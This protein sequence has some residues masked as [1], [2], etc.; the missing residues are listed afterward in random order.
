MSEQ[1][2]RLKQRRKGHRGVVT[3]LIKEAASLLEGERVEKSITRLRIIDEQLTEKLKVLRGFDEDMVT[4]IDVKEIENDVLEAEA[5]A[6][7]VSQLCGEIKAYLKKPDTLP[8]GMSTDASVTETSEITRRNTPRLDESRVRP[9]LPKLY[10][11]KFSGEVIHFQSFWESFTSAVHQN[12]DLSV[13]DKFNYLKGLVEGPAASAIQGLTL[14][15]GNYAAALELLKERFGKKQNIIAAHME[16]L[17]KLPN[18]NGDK[19]VQIRLVYDKIN[20]NV[21]ALEALGIAREQYGCLLI[22]VIMTKLPYN[23]RLQI[24]RLTKRDV[25]VVDELL[26]V[27]KNEVEAREM[28]E[29]MKF[30]DTRN[31]D[32]QKRLPPPT[33]ASLLV[34]EDKSKRKVQCI[35]CKAEHYSASCEKINTISGRVAVL[36]REGRCFLCLSNGHRVSECSVNRRCRK[37]GRKHHQS[38]CEQNIAPEPPKEASG[39][40][41]GSD[42]S[43]PKVT[44]VARCKNE[45]LLQTARTFAYTAN[46]DLVPVRILMDA[47]SQRSYLSNELKMRLKLKPLKQETL[48]VNTFGSE[49]FNKK[50]CDLVKVRLQAKQGKDV[51]ITALSYHAICSPLQIPV[52]PQQYS[53]LQELDLADTS[54]SK[55][56]SDKV[57]MLI[58][59]DFYWDIVTGDIKRGNEGPTAVSSKFGWLLSGPVNAGNKEVN[60]ALSNLVIEGVGSLSEQC[61]DQD[62]S[63]DLHRFWETESIG[64]AEETQTASM[65]SLFVDL[66]YDWILGRYQVTLPWKTDFRPQG[67]GYEISMAR[68]N[69]LRSKLQR[70]KSLFQQYDATFKMQV[71]DGIIEHIPSKTYQDGCYFLPHHAVIKTDRETTKLR[72]VF[73]AS[74]KANKT[75]LSLN[76]CLEKGPNGIPHIF[77]LL[78]NFRSHP[79]G[80]TADIEKAFH[81]IVIDPKDR[82]ALRFLWIDDIL[83]PRPEVIQ[84][85]FCRLVFGLTPSPAILTETIQYHLTRFLLKEP[86]MAELLSQ[87]FYVDDLICGVQNEE[88]GIHT[89]EKARQLMASGGFNLR[90]WRTNS[91]SLQQKIDSTD[92]TTIPSEVEG[93]KILGLTWDT[94]TDDFHFS[95][96]DV[97]MFAKSLPPT[98]RSV[99]KTSSKLFDPLGLFSPIIIAAKILFQIL[100]KDK[101]DW[102][103][104]LTE[105][106]LTKWEQFTN[107]LDVMSQINVPRYYHI[108]ELTPATLEIHGLVMPQKRPMQQSFI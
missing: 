16:E 108:R 99:L 12:P 100:C 87:S 107:D 14:S 10:L 59:S 22:P 23:I 5:I 66:K 58:G 13:I 46:S 17:V 63:N 1:L 30:F 47:G 31:M 26:E 3:R 8:V 106:S 64:I 86:E 38:L 77:N 95:F 79:I 102:D 71:Q 85:R 42:T 35:F 70:D 104:T 40:T 32:Q 72:I 29:S 91:E 78:L 34:Q 33:A 67:N 55:H 37:C 19:A 18:C 94:K 57:D 51:E 88:Q 43:T 56:S 89:Y 93:V 45:V 20:V 4:L 92:N 39:T 53:H 80:L 103:Q 27:I 52:Q 7:K 90:K 25:W 44:T 76:D 41:E 50:K 98:K 69:Q 84:Y 83:K 97:M 101:V 81:Q 11:P 36:K 15:E 73:D 2:E 61:S 75:S 6:D 48:T 65:S 96:K 28:S 82:D 105:P 24:A 9:K 68:L 60:Y 74:A 54:A 49:E 62:L 21:R